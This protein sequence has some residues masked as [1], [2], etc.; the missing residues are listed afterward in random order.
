[1][2][3]LLPALRDEMRNGFKRLESRFDQVETRLERLDDRVDR[4]F[5]WIVGIQFT[6]MIIFIGA[7]VAA[8]LR[9]S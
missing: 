3:T 1:M 4:H 8:I 9:M 7:L 5:T 6:T 2:E